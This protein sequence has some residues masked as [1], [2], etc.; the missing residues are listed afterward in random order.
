MIVS[1]TRLSVRAWR[2]MPGFV[3]YT[4]QSKRQLLRSPGFVGGLLASAPS[5]TFWTT[6]AWTDEAAMKRYRDSDWHKRAMPK[7]LHWCDEASVARWTQDTS[8]LPTA[9]GMLD[10]MK[11]AGRTSKVRHPS[12]GHAAGQTVPD[13]LA[14]RPGLPIRPKTL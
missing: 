13:G 8:E 7:L 1:L 14:P 10:K 6:T 5:R 4:Y 9:A 3:W 12:P 2:Y 11:A